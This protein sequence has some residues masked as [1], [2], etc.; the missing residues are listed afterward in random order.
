MIA[1]TV[2]QQNMGGAA[3]RLVALVLGKDRIAGKPGVDQDYRL[4]DFQ[5]EAGVAKPG[6]FHGKAPFLA[7]PHPAKPPGGRKVP[8]ARVLAPP[9]PPR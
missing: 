7:L 8:P 6:Q 2:G 4:F 5:P 3:D 1:V 9:R